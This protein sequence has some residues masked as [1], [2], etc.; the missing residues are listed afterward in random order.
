MRVTDFFLS[1]IVED[2]KR[3]CIW[4][5]TRAMIVEMEQ[6]GLKGEVWAMHVFRVLVSELGGRQQDPNNSIVTSEAIT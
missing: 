3:K 4:A 5:Q 1:G 2:K 6:M